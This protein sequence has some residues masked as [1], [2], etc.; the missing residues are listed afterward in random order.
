MTAAYVLSVQY[1]RQN[2][3]PTYEYTSS[4]PDTKYPVGQSLMYLRHLIKG[5][6][7]SRRPLEHGD[8]R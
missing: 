7:G 4:T 5:K 1:E 6:P 8:L 3:T 2:A